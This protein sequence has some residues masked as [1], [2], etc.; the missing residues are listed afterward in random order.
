MMSIVT[1]AGIITVQR[2]LAM[3]LES[4]TLLDTFTDANRKENP[5]EFIRATS[6]Y[7]R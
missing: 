6:S 7:Q 3:M 2:E 1:A 4:R 5:R